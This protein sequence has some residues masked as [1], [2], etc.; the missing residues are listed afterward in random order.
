MRLINTVELFLFIFLF[1]KYVFRKYQTDF[2]EE[3]QKLD[4]LLVEHKLFEVYE[5]F[6]S[7]LTVHNPI[8]VS[9]FFKTKRKIKNEF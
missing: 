8:A 7:A 1:L 4:T 3:L 6:R 2:V 5:N 9:F